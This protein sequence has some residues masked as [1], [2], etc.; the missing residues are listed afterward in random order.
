MI[1]KYALTIVSAV[2]LTG[3]VA[4]ALNNKAVAQETPPEAVL[5]PAIDVSSFFSYQGYLTQGGVAVN[6]SCDFEFRLYNALTAG[7]QVGPTQPANGQAISAGRFTV[8]LNFGPNAVDGQARWLQIA[9]RCP[10]GS[11]AF[12]TLSPRQVLTAAPYALSLRPGA[13]VTG[14]VSSAGIL[15]LTNNSDS[16]SDIGLNVLSAPIGVQVDSASYIGVQVNSAGG[17]GVFVD[18]SGSN[19]FQVYSAGNDGVKVQSAAE[20]G[21]G[22]DSAGYNGI[23]VDSAGNNGLQVSSA[24]NNGVLVDSAGI[25]SISYYSSLQDGLEVAGAEGFGLYV[26]RADWDGVRIRS[27]ADDGIQI[28]E[29]GIAPNF[30]VFVPEPGTTHET[31]MVNTAADNGQ[32]A[33]YTTDQIYAGNIG[34]SAQ[35]LVAVA[36]GDLTAGDAVSAVGLADPIPNSLNH[37]AQVRVADATAGV[38]GVVESRMELQPAPGKEG[39]MVLHS[40]AGPAKAGDYVSITVL[41]AAQVKVQAGKAIQPGQRVTVGANGAVRA[42]QTR[43]IEGMV[44]SEGAPTIGVA[45]QEPKDGLIWVLVSPQ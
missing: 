34:L 2:L 3:L 37:L 35:T 36:D 9:V 12:T 11:G 39:V 38:V 32:W 30:G 44:V 18:S 1:R 17:A 24:D 41:G 22:V 40:V 13:A 29:D 4:L 31:L 20:N 25:P 15:N 33:L 6:G 43:T 16:S 23:Q 27:T 28:G 21:V 42:L 5:A 26:G 8:L 19:G 10:S 14:D 7:T 45:L